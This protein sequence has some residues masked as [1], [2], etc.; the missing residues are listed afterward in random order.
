MVAVSIASCGSANTEIW[1]VSRSHLF[2]T[3]RCNARPGAVAGPACVSGWMRRSCPLRAGELLRPLGS[4]RPQPT[5]P[6]EHAACLN[7]ERG[8]GGGKAQRRE[9]DGKIRVDKAKMMKD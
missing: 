8:G 6:D 3:C 5:P 4:S 7:V 2:L 1:Q 9:R